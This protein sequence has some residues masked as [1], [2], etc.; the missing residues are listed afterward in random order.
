MAVY[1]IYFLGKAAKS[2]RVSSRG[3]SNTASRLVLQPG[4]APQEDITA[5]ECYVAGR[6]VATDLMAYPTLGELL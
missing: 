2:V 6:E 4:N 1:D 3:S 5:A